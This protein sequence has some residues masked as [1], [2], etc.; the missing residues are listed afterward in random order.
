MELTGFFAEAA[1][2]HTAIDILKRSGF[3]VD[4]ANIVTG[5]PAGEHLRRFVSSERT[6]R[7]VSSALGSS[8]VALIFA[9][10]LLPPSPF[11]FPWAAVGGLVLIAA[12]L[13]GLAGAC[14]GMAVD[15]DLVL[16]EMKIPKDHLNEASHILRMAGGRYVNACTVPSYSARIATK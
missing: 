1:Y 7:I 5:E 8:A 15:H 13:G 16:F 3:D 14:F 11:Q 4:S 12:A 2:A 10:L 9:A 6:R